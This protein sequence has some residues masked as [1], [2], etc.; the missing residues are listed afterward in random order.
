M[1]CPHHLSTFIVGLGPL[2][3][4][5][6]SRFDRAMKPSLIQAY[7]KYIQLCVT[8]SNLRTLKKI[9][10]ILNKTNE[11]Q[12]KPQK[13]KENLNKTNENQVKP[14]KIKKTNIK[15]IKTKSIHR[16]PKKTLAKTQQ[17]KKN[18]LPDPMPTPPPRRKTKKT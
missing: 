7:Q 14:Q 12:I 11:N 3:G 13:N 6:L 2:R 9:K 17:T 15:P 4:R 18:K 10:E 1:W 8:M 5:R 16:K